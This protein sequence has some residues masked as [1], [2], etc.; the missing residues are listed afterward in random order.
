MKIMKYWII[1]IALIV[2]AGLGYLL[3]TPGEDVKEIPERT[4]PDTF[5]DYW[6]QGLAEISSYKLIQYR[7]GEPREGT[8]ALIFVTEP[9]LKSKQVKA[10]NPDNSKA[11]QVMKLNAT[12]NFTTGIYPY[13]LMSSTFVPLSQRSH[14]LKI[15]ASITEWCGQ[16][17]TQLNNRDGFEVQLHSYFESEGD[18]RSNHKKHWLENELWVLLR[19]DPNTL[20]TGNFLSYPSLEYLRLKH[21]PFQPYD[22]KGVLKAQG[23]NMMYEVHWPELDR[24]LTLYFE[25]EFPYKI[26]SWE[27]KHPEAG[28][29]GLKLVTD[30]G[31]LQSSMQSPYWGKNSNKDNYLREK[32]GL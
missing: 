9:F 18:S 30:K 13:H 7:Y 17:F 29:N 3:S 23:D 12:R 31:I 26:T 27:E 8:A 11:V 14:A 6:H 21:L 22:T 20:P 4:L 28:E 10:D 32:L 15:T 5:G 2:L 1:F 16:V 19:I 25:P 24:T